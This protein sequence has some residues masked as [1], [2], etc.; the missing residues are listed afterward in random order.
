MVYLGTDP[1]VQGYRRNDPTIAKPLMPQ[2]FSI[3]DCYRYTFFLPIA[4][5]SLLEVCISRSLPVVCATAIKCAFGWIS[6]ITV[7][8]IIKVMVGRLRPNFLALNHI[9][10]DGSDCKEIITTIDE[11]LNQG[12]SRQVARSSRE[13]FYSLHAAE[14]TFA[15]SL[16]MLQFHRLVTNSYSMHSI[17][18][19]VSN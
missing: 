7:S 14:G 3:G 17:C 2:L 18:V 10:F 11:H 16:M 13:S 4:V 15:A 1:Y 9:N 6:L 12:I 5:I 19:Q 8:F